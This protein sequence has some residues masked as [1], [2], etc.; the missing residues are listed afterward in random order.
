MTSRRRVF[1]STREFRKLVFL[2]VYFVLLA[3][4]LYTA[5]LGQLSW[6]VV[7]VSAIAWFALEARENRGRLS[8]AM[9]VG[10]FLLVFDFIFENSGWR[11]G[12]GTPRASSTWGWC[13]FR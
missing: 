8:S 10:A 6:Y 4:V 9:K 1:T 3:F 12:C 13:R 5:P 11:G 2:T 7:L